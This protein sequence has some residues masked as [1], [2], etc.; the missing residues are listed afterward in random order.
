MDL[1]RKTFKRFV[2]LLKSPTLK[3]I[4]IYPNDIR[5]FNIKQIQNE[6]QSEL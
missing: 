2:T 5:Q 4:K 6:L 3:M 1:K